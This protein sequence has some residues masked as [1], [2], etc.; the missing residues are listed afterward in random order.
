MNKLMIP[1]IL[2]ATVM[3]A[4][5][6]AFMPVEQATTVHTTILG[7]NVAIDVVDEVV[8]DNTA[9]TAFDFDLNLA[10]I[11]A[12]E[13]FTATFIIEMTD[14][15]TAGTVT[16]TVLIQV[17]DGDGF[18]D[19]AV[20]EPTPANAGSDTAT[21]TVAGESSGTGVEIRF[22]VDEG[23]EATEATLDI[24]GFAKRI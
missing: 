4:G 9:T 21:I 14:T 16:S 24:Q 12:G 23:V 18:V 1:V 8:G 3:V 22:T 11:A 6:F 17:F 13:H 15:D 5:A 7:T 10:G 2:V 20:A 19:A